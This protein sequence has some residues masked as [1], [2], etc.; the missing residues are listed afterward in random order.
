MN[1]YAILAVGAGGFLGSIARYVSVALLDSKVKSII[2]YGT[3]FVNVSGSFIL[4]LLIGLLMKG[5]GDQNWKLFFTTG[6]CGGFT[7]FSAF[8]FENTTL[9]QQKLILPSLIYISASI[10]LGIISVGA[11]LA[12]GKFLNQ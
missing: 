9:L 12:V 3:L 10:F 1:V 2:P 11:G 8:A 7:T 6:F 5:N 4:G